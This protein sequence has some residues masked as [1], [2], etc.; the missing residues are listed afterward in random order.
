MPER[1][2][3]QQQEKGPDIVTL[4]SKDCRSVPVIEN[5]ARGDDGRLI[6][7]EGSGQPLQV[8]QSV[9]QLVPTNC[10]PLAT[11]QVPRGKGVR[12]QGR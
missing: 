4:V 1:A 12:R 7:L 8:R 11:T 5:K 6:R 10:Q 3:T 9:Q 2:W